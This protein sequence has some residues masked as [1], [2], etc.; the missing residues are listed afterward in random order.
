MLS[1]TIC[2]TLQFDKQKK[3]DTEMKTKD[4]ALDINVKAHSL[5][6]EALLFLFTEKDFYAQNI[7]E[8]VKTLIDLCNKWIELRDEQEGV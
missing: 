8:K 1:L 6:E 4:I 2:M 3:E 7:D 5:S